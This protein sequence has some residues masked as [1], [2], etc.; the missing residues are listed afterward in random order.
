ME[1]RRI[2]QEKSNQERRIEKMKINTPLLKYR[3]R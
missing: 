3:L 1:H 2:W